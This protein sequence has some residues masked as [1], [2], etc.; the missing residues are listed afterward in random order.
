MCDGVICD[1]DSFME[2]SCVTVLLY[3]RFG[4]Y[5]YRGGDAFMACMCLCVTVVPLWNNLCMTVI[6]DKSCPIMYDGDWR[7]MH[8][9]VSR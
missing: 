5:V 3:H 7:H 2:Y 6:L 1:G 9:D 4:I 8:L